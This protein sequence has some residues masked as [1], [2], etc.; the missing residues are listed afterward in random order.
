MISFIKR[1]KDISDAT[2]VANDVLAG[3]TFY[4]ANGKQTGLMQNNGELNYTP[5]TEIQTI[6]EGYTSG[7]TI[8]ASKQTNDDYE[9]CLALSYDILK[10]YVLL[11]YIQSS[12]RQYIDTGVVPNENTVVEIEFM[13]LEDNVNYERIFGVKD[14][15]EVLRDSNDSNTD[16]WT[17][18]INRTANNTGISVKIGSFGYGKNILKTT[19]SS[20][21]LNGVLINEFSKLTPNTGKTMYLFY[22]NNADRYGT[23]RLYS[24]KIYNNTELIRDFV[25]MLDKDSV[26]CLYDNIT[27]TF[28][29]N[30][31]SG[32][33]I[34]GEE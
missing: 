11:K 3:K 29:Y 18:K 28:F 27:K 17:F 13:K 31:G 8:E 26:V 9:D 34:G 14:Y 21:Y 19:T 5:S 1:G 20:V 2:A 6:P 7:G 30:Q 33:F 23:F 4:N 10:G 16:D 32:N 24:C 15:Y 12:G 25:P 22:A